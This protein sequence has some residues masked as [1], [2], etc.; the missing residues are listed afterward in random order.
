M[1]SQHNESFTL[2]VPIHLFTPSPYSS[3]SLTHASPGLFTLRASAFPN[4]SLSSFTLK[5]KP[6][7]EA[8]FD[9]MNDRMSFVSLGNE[10]MLRALKAAEG[11]HLE[12]S[13]VNEA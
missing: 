12:R 2:H 7:G 6:G 13:H 5:L 3:A 1:A 11:A 4:L 10:S 8:P 9:L